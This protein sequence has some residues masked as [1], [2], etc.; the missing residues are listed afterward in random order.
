MVYGPVDAEVNFV[1]ALGS[2]TMV[3]P[4]VELSAETP[5]AVIISEELCRGA[6]AAL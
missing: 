4:S 5:S 2:P 6:V 3:P 1:P